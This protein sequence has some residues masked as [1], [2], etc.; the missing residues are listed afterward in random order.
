MSLGLLIL[1]LF[2]VVIFI[3]YN[4]ILL[5][6]MKEYGIENL[7]YYLCLLL[8]VDIILIVSSLLWTFSWLF[9]IKLW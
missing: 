9:T 7:D 8:L 6:D 1:I 2:I 4:I 3:L 5:H